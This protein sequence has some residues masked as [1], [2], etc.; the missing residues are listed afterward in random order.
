MPVEVLA[1]SVVAHG[2]TRVG[3]PSRDLDVAQVDPCAEHR[4]AEGAPQ[5]VRVHPRQSDTAPASHPEDPMP[6]F[7]AQVVDVGADGFKDPQPEQA[8]RREGRRGC[9]TASRW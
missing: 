9:R 2:G 6:V 8:H 4:G 7:L 1:G 5:H 3:V